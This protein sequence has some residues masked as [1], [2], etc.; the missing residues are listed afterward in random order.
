MRQPRRLPRAARCRGADIGALR[1]GAA[2]GGR[3]VTAAARLSPT[4]VKTDQLAG[5]PAPPSLLV[6]VPELVK[7]YYTE[8]P[9]PFAP[10]QR[11]VFGTSGHRG[12]SLKAE[13]T[14]AHILAITQA[15]CLY[16]QVHEIASKSSLRPRRLATR[17]AHSPRSVGSS[18]SR[19]QSPV[20]L[21]TSDVAI[22]TSPGHV[23]IHH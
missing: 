19:N 13:F 9:D 1:R 20:R 17:R 7:A 11:V 6:D 23:E 16:R 2:V 4:T 8:R 14:E 15:I 12:S 22:S 3:A 10:K 21:T 18:R 5:R